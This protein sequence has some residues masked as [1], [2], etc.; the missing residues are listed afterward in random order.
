MSVKKRISGMLP[1]LVTP[2]INGQVAYQKFQDTIVE[3]NKTGLSGYVVLGSNGETVY[4]SNEEKLKLVKAARSVIPKDKHLVVGTGL[5][6]INETIWLSN[7]CAKLGA[8]FALILTPSYFGTGMTHDAMIKYFVDVAD[9]VKIPV[10]IYN[11][12][13]FTN[14]ELQPRTVAQLAKHPNIIGIKHSSLNIAHLIE[15]VSL[16]PP[17]FCVLVGTASI[18]YPGLAVGAVGGVCALANVTPKELVQ[19]QKL[20]EQGNRKEALAIQ[21]RLMAIN[22][23]VTGTY[24][25]PGLKAAMDFVGYF[26]G[27]ARL[28]LLPLNADGKAA[29]KKF[30]RKL[31]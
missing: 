21:Q 10:I 15:Y 28:P 27:E 30:C 3:L 9:A 14:I 2:F 4:L 5:E 19:I 11:V 12:P 7:E 17:D 31:S 29:I 25:V 24:G 1:P 20:F 26:G 6:S 16:T 23:A 8:D 18:L 22:T 13:K